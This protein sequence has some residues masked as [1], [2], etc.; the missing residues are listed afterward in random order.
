MRDVL[1]ARLVSVRGVGL[2]HREKQPG[3]DTRRE[4]VVINFERQLESSVWVAVRDQPGRGDRCC[5]LVRSWRP[6]A[7]LLVERLT[8]RC[9]VLERPAAAGERGV[10]AEPV[11]FEDLDRR[12]RIELGHEHP[13]EGRV[14]VRHDAR[15]A[16]EVRELFAW[17]LPREVRRVECVFA[18]VG[19]TGAGS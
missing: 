1:Q 11:G 16:R 12:V 17:Q 8:Q 2:D 15:D 3:A 7:Q 5:A 10:P 14:E 18:P 4:L 6:G 13:R 9:D 19:D